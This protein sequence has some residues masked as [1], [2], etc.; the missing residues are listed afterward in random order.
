MAPTQDRKEEVKRERVFLNSAASG[1]E[2]SLAL[3]IKLQDLVCP[4]EFILALV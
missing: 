2:S 4:D 1:I 3:G